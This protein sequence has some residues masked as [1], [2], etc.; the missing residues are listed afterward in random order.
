MEKA[1]S[2]WQTLF[3]LFKIVN[4]VHWWYLFLWKAVNS[5]SPLELYYTLWH[6][7][8]LLYQEHHGQRLRESE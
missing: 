6:C 5:N 2:G 4:D 3:P 7:T 1:H 8:A